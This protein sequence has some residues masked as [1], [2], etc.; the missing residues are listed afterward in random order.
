MINW[1]S[2]YIAGKTPYNV[3]SKEILYLYTNYKTN[4]S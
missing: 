4:V 2:T 3:K 1:F